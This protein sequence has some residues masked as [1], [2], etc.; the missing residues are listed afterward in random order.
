MPRHVER[1]CVKERTKMFDRKEAKARSKVALKSNYWRTF[2]VALILFAII[3]SGAATFNTA[4]GSGVSNYSEKYEIEEEEYRNDLELFIGEIGEGRFVA[5]VIAIIVA[6]C[7]TGIVALII[8]IFLL[9]PLEVGCRRFFLENSDAPAPLGNLAYGFDH[10]YLRTVGAI[11][12]RDLYMVLWSLLFV[13]PGVVKYYSYFLVP[14]I[15]IDNPDISG[16]EAITL[17]RNMMKG[18]KWE[19]FVMELSF[20]LW[21]FLCAITLGLVAVFY[22]NP[23][24]AGTHAEFYKQIKAEYEED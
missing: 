24:I 10:G 14:Y 5:I 9:N 6:L 8:D 15:L 23:Y 19:A 18:H 21:Y 11:F 2:L 17:S 12:R 16:G 20:I 13:I 3:G 4:S 1:F 22:V 7:L